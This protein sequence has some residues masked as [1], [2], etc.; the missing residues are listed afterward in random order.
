MPLTAM[1]AAKKACRRTGWRLSNLELQKILYLAQLRYKRAN[2]GGRLFSALFEAWDYGPV[3]PEVYHKAKAFGSDP[4]QNVFH[5]VKD[6]QHP[7]DKDLFASVDLL[8]SSSPAHLVG[9]THRSKGAWAT[10]YRPGI[11]GVIIPDSAIDREAELF[12]TP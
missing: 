2:R 3:I 4:V 12:K 1:E 9:M 11:R 6:E 10:F 5:G 7:L 8:K